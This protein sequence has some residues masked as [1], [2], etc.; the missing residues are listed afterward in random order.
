M[1]GLGILAMVAIKIPYMIIAMV[2]IGL[3]LYKMTDIYLATAQDVKRYTIAHFEYIFFLLC[4][5]LINFDHA[6]SKESPEVQ[7]FLIFRQLY[8]D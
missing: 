7:Y 1:V 3:I 8:P 5:E 4:F 6:E 2:L